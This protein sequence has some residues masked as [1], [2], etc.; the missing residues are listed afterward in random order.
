MPIE[1]GTRF[2]RY[3]ILAPLGVGGMGEVYLALDPKLGRKV[4]LKLLPEKYTKD[5]LRLRRFEQ[6]AQAASALNHP[7]I[8]TIH[9]IGEVEGILFIA[10]EFIEGITLRKRLAVKPLSIRETLDTAIQIANALAAAHAAG[11]VHRDI[12]PENIML[13]PDGYVKVLDFGLAKLIEREESSSTPPQSPLTESLSS[14][15]STQTL[16]ASDPKNEIPVSPTVAA[17]PIDSA[18]FDQPNPNRT[19]EQN[20]SHSLSDER[21]ATIAD[22][23]TKHT[24]P[25]LVLG[26]LHYMSPEQARGR[27]VDRRT[28]IFSLGIV[29]YEMLAGRVPFDGNSSKAIIN[30]IL[31]DEALPLTELRPET[32]DLLEWIVAKALI[33]EREERYQTAREILNDLKRLQQRLEVETELARN[34]RNR[35]GET[36]NTGEQRLINARQFINDSDADLQLGGTP[37]KS[38]SRSGELFA[39]VRHN[40]NAGLLSRYPLP[41]FFFATCLLLLLGALLYVSVISRKY[42]ALPFGETRITRFTTSGKVLRAAISPDGK[43][44]VYAAGDARR[45]SLSV[46]QVVTMSNVEIVPTAQ[47]LYRGLTFS[48]DGN[49]IFY[50]VQESNNPIQALYQLP[51]LGGTPRKLI[52]DIDS[53]V[54]LS[55]DG[56][57]L[58][59]VRRMRSTGEDVLM[60][61][62]VDGGN[63]H[64]LATRA[65]TEFFHVTGL[66]WSPDGKT[67]L[68]P[69]GSREGRRRMFYVTVRVADG[70]VKQVTDVRWSTVGRAAWMPDGKAIVVSGI[71][72]GTTQTQIWLLRY[73]SGEARRITNDLNDYRD[74]SLTADGQTLITV[75]TEAQVHISLLPNGDS[76]QARQITTGVSRYNGVRGMSWTPDGRLVYVSRQ[77]GSQDI[78]IMN[79]DGTNQKQLTT[80]EMRADVNPSVT[81]DGHYIVFTSS[82]TGF[83]NLYRMAL[84][85]SDQVQLTSG[86]GEE[87]LVT[88]SDSQ[89]VIYVD[90]SSSLFTL[91]RVSIEGGTPVQ[92]TKKLS[93]RPAMSPDGKW[94]AC[95][96]RAETEEPWRLAILPAAGGPPNQ[97]LTLPASVETSLPVR[98]MA[99]SS[100]LCFLD[101]RNGLQNIWAISLAGEELKQLTNFTGEQIFWF[102]WS[103]DGKQLAVSRGS[104]TNDVVMFAAIKN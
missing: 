77:S 89:S 88:A 65:G 37:T 34:R 100:A 4:A 55:A 73:P 104:L 24:L 84:D 74:L 56:S 39:F 29:L 23:P 2:D 14:T 63:P 95:W 79:A 48:P 13:R 46:R 80:P 10:T 51:V 3:Q 9:E 45:Q 75:Q 102:E 11:I 22:V 72:T 8:I 62:D 30:S 61:A 18:H 20:F 43:Y 40:Q 101:D 32:P 53:P 42:D 35:S 49:F 99:D 78:W 97:L 21:F 36:Q 86:A 47:V 67:I 19:T 82:R 38:R 93:T 58:A 64:P 103:P 92:L 50:V 44:V 59:F 12:K 6:E 69:A 5:P 87:F 26:T 17:N 16:S 60:I 27:Q 15:S 57:Q 52:T 94:I 96:Y 54:A 68:C 25:G 28:D 81:P 71:E 83:S 33:K 31:A 90:T 91:W 98:W 76:T 70:E 7:N 85:G 41:T 1:T 66:A